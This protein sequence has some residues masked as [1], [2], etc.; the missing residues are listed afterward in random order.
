MSFICKKWCKLLGDFHHKAGVVYSVLSVMSILGYLLRFF[1]GGG[2]T[3]PMFNTLWRGGGLY[4]VATFTNTDRSNIII[5]LLSCLAVF[6][7]PK[8]CSGFILLQCLG[9]TVITREREK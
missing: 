6:Q 5:V 4:I 2:G 7:T 1:G 8:F 3:S 9:V